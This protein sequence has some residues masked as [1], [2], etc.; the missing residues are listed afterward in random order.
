MSFSMGEIKPGSIVYLKKENLSAYLPYNY[1]KTYQNDDRKYLDVSDPLCMRAYPANA[2]KLIY[3]RCEGP[4]TIPSVKVRMLCDDQEWILPY[5][6][7]YRVERME[8]YPVFMSKQFNVEATNNRHVSPRYNPARII[9]NDPATVVFWKD[10]TKTVVKRM[11]KEKFNPYT[12]FCAALAK[13]IFGNNSRVCKIVNGGEDHSKKS[14]K[15][16]K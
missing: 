12:A 6:M 10:G 15:K 8:D 1:V 14:V 9:Y 5:N 3:L 16:K 11:P 7:I 2:A 4:N 13:K